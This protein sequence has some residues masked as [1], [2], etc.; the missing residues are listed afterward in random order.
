M[1]LP[2]FCIQE[3]SAEPVRAELAH[4][5]SNLLHSDKQAQGRSHGGGLTGLGS[6]EEGAEILANLL[7]L[8]QGTA[9]KRA[10]NVNVDDIDSMRNA[11][12]SG[13]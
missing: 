10:D 12:S 6:P 8:Q 1:R 9:L 13:E 11:S 5:A 4:S 2:R 7:F 3:W